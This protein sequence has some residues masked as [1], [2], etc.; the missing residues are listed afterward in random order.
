RYMSDFILHVNM[1]AKYYLLLFFIFTQLLV[2]AQ[3]SSLPF[4]QTFSEDFIL[5]EDVEF[6]ENWYGNLVR[7][8]SRIF[9]TVD[10]EL[11]IIPTSNFDGD[12]YARLD[13]RGKEKV[14]VS[15]NAKSVKNEDGGNSSLLFM[16]T[17]TNG[18]FSWNTRKLI[19]VFENI[20][21]D[22][23]E[24]KYV[25]A[26]VAS[27]NQQAAV[28]FFVTTGEGSGKAAQVVIDNVKFFEEAFDVTPP[29]V[30]EVRVLHNKS[31]QVK[32]NEPI[33]VASATNANNYQGLPI[34][35][36]IVSSPDRLTITLEFAQGLEI[37]K[38]YNLIIDNIKDD[39]GNKQELPFRQRVVY[40]NSRP[41]IYITELM[42]N[43]PLV[44][45]DSLEFL[46]IYNAGLSVAKLGGLQF[47]S[48]IELTFPEYDLPADSY[49]SIASN[50]RAAKD[51]YGVNFL[52]WESGALNN[53]GELLE[54]KNSEGRLVTSVKY[55]RTW[56]GD[57]NGHSISYCKPQDQTQND[58]SLLWASTQKALGKS[59]NGVPIY[60]SPNSGC[61]SVTP[62]VRFETYSTYTLESETQVNLVIQR[63]NNNSMDSQVTIE[64]DDNSTAIFGEDFS[65][66]ASFPL[67]LTFEPGVGTIEIGIDILDNDKR[68]G[69][70]T[71]VFNL[72]AL[73]NSVI[74]GRG[75]FE[76]SVLSSNPAISKVCI[77]ELSAS[78]NSISGIEDEYGDYDD[79]VELK[80]N[81]DVPI[82][83][84]GY[85][86]T[87]NLN[88]LTKHQLSLT[89]TAS[90]TIPANGYLIL[91]ADGEPHQG[92]NHLS[93]RLS[94][95]LGED[96]AIVTPDGKTIIEEVSFPPLVTNTSY[97]RSEDCG[98]HWMVF[99]TPSFK[100]PNQ[101]TSVIYREGAAPITLYPNP[102]G[103]RIL[104]ISEPID[105]LLYNQN[106]QLLKSGEYT[107]EIDVSSLSN[108]LYFL[109][110]SEGDV[111]KFIVSR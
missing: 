102:N 37:G 73:N 30:A 95:T 105:Y 45:N 104:N 10:K 1:R 91:W 23:L 7:N 79:W 89:D 100:A 82:V 46:E 106:G 64:L 80:N 18:G 61:E 56:G 35:S 97:G 75:Y 92:G 44:D 70:R 63:I 111:V 57:G 17:S 52:E 24:Y 103:G 68:E 42:Y 53:G 110:T 47:T 33:D 32:Y 90:L 9:Q 87:D 76:L 62:E 27:D 94:A 49:V 3:I 28:R 14:A 58:N 36:K 2:K 12:V 101:P 20:D 108:G 25:L 109:R 34:I 48:G 60:V 41:N 99:Q 96:F 21:T 39:S 19:H 26:G 15:F 72:V 59:I 78:N 71:A 66:T 4:T 77:N 107:Q 85:F 43:S 29:E 11:A 6:I 13:L 86:V 54:I 8:D 40:N 93:F 88:N 31:V 65:S 55:I 51:F 5:G 84:S 69:I 74:G 98:G 38:D 83:L 50:A 67:T 16:E 81:S 22:F